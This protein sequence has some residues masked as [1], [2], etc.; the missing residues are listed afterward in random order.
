MLKDEFT[1]FISEKLK[2]VSPKNLSLMEDFKRSAV[3]MPLFLADDIPHILLTLRTEKVKDHQK[4]ISFPGGTVKENESLLETALRETYEEIGVRGDE[5]K[6][7]GEL[8]EIFTLT[9]Y[10]IKPFVGFMDY[11]REFKVSRDE[12]EEIIFVKIEDLLKKENFRKE[13]RGNFLGEP[14]PVYFFTIGNITIWGATAKII[15]NFLEVVYNW[16]E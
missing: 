6:I 10:R 7:L 5:I 3:I 13:I 12:I 11:P 9:Y 16:K 15:K 1:E 8:N 4:Q 14:Y 2:S